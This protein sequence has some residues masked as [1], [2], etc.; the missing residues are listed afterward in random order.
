MVAKKTKLKQEVA[1]P[2]VLCAGTRNRS[3]NVRLKFAENVRR[4]FK[5]KL[6]GLFGV[7]THV[8]H[9]AKR[10]YDCLR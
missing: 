6:A 10:K 7:L 4:E 5:N 2:V 3:D 1:H 9:E 8:Q